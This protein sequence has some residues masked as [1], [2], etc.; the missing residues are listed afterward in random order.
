[1]AAGVGE[2]EEVLLLEVVC[3]AL[4]EGIGPPPTM[5]SAAPDEEAC[6]PEAPA[7]G[8]APSAGKMPSSASLIDMESMA[9]ICSE[10]MFSRISSIVALISS[11]AAELLL[12]NS[13]RSSHRGSNLV[14]EA[15][16]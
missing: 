12:F 4:P 13:A 5:G 16:P 10:V 2:T 9:L 11:G 7:A 15:E 8:A 6:V 3:C 14:A 1:M